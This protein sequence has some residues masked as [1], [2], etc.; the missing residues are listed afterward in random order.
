MRRAT[1]TLS[2]GTFWTRAPCVQSPSGSPPLRAQWKRGWSC[3]TLTNALVT[4]LCVALVGNS[5]PS[6]FLLCFAW[7]SQWL[8][9][10]RGD[11]KAKNW[12]ELES[13]PGDLFL[14]VPSVCPAHRGSPFDY[15]SILALCPLNGHYTKKNLLMLANYARSTHEKKKIVSLKHCLSF[16]SSSTPDFRPV[17]CIS[18]RSQQALVCACWAVSP[19]YYEVSSRTHLTPWS[20]LSMPDICMGTGVLQRNDEWTPQRL[21]KHKQNV[22]CGITSNCYIHWYVLERLI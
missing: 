16:E 4:G 13:R 17:D 7:S 3:S 1:P 5:F 6:R 15:I 21:L 12:T 9:G 19:S 20:F 10:K 11:P 22:Q 14:R 2:C 8:W 18:L